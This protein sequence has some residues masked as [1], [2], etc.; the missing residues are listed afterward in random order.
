LLPHLPAPESSQVIAERRATYAC[1]PALPRP[2]AGMLLPRLALAGDYTD[3]ELPA[4]LEAA[5]RSGVIAARALLA[6]RH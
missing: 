3:A 4:T 6:S 5:A 1:T 2:T